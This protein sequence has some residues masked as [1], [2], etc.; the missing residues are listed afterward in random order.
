MNENDLN[1]IDKG[2]K[3]MDEPNI[4]ETNMNE[5]CSECGFILEQDEQDWDT[6]VCY[7]CGL[8]WEKS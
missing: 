5:N 2:E 1:I 6:L 4:K 8:G 7:K 3:V